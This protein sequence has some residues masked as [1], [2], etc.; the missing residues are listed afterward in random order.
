MGLGAEVLLEAGWFDSSEGVK[1]QWNLWCSALLIHVASAVKFL[2][3][4][5]GEGSFGD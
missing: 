4:L 1:L 3:G 2:E 5:S